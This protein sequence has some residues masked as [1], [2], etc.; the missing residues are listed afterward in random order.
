MADPIAC[1]FVGDQSVRRTLSPLE[2]FAQKALGRT[3]ITPMLKQDI[4]HVA[5]LVNGSPATLKLSL[6]VHEHLVEKPVVA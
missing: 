2:K 6:Y 3:A 5:V 1:E 4:E